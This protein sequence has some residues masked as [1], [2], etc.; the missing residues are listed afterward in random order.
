MKKINEKYFTVADLPTSQSIIEQLLLQTVLE[1]AEMLDMRR[2]T[3][4]LLKSIY[5]FRAIGEKYSF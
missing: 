1:Q 2:E 4:E 5:E 3:K